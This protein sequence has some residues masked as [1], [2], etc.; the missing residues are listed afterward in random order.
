MP[1]IFM[2]PKL[3]PPP[4]HYLQQ[5]RNQ[6]FYG[7]DDVLEK[8]DKILLPLDSNNSDVEANHAPGLN[9]FALCGFGGLGKSE[10]AIE[11]IHTW[12]QDLMRYSGRGSERGPEAMR[13]MVKALINPVCTLEPDTNE[14][15]TSTTWLMVFDNTDMPHL[16]HDIIPIGGRSIIITSRNP[17]AK[18]LS[19][20]DLIGL[21]LHAMSNETAGGLLQKFSHPDSKLTCMQIASRL[22][23]FPLAIIQMAHLIQM[24]HLSLT[25][26]PPN[27]T[28]LLRALSVF[29]GDLIPEDVLSTV[30]K[31]VKPENYPK[32][33]I[34]Y[35]EAQQAPMKSSLITRNVE[36]GFLRIHRLVQEVV[37]QG[38]DTKALGDMFSAT[39][40]LIFG[41]WPFLDETCLNR[42]DRLRKVQRYFSQVTM[43][44][45]ILEVKTVKALDLNVDV[46]ALFN[47]A[48]CTI[49][50]SSKLLADSYRYQGVT[51]T[52]IGDYLRDLAVPSTEKW[53][54][55]LVES[56]EKYQQQTD[57]N[58]LS[59]GYNEYW[60]S[61]M[62][63]PNQEEAEKSC[64]MSCETIRQMNWAPGPAYS[65]DPEVGYSRLSPILKELQEKLDSGVTKTLYTHAGLLESVLTFAGDIRWYRP[66][67]ARASWELRRTLLAGG[68]PDNE[69]EARILLDSVMKLRRELQPEDN[70]PEKDPTDDWE[71]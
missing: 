34:E 4:C 9:V 61:L 30:G 47:V 38:L 64:A 40:V 13:D 26:L 60:I 11:Y 70:R 49:E 32:N 62:R 25:D 31:N 37:R 35:F 66:W 51:A 45:S 15:D 43:L 3:L 57:I 18:Q 50:L 39:V 54:E 22:G 20:A 19:L 33:K 48:S 69:D 16:L 65:S 41:V 6:N 27:A 7:Q 28:A 46:A 10:I 63:L 56:I 67:A 52:Q 59:I 29:D 23:G 36:L 71:L 2:P 44:R 1:F 21:G 8:M 17:L 42:T 24:K 58:T 14:D 55:L 12:K 68:Q 53:I 5:N